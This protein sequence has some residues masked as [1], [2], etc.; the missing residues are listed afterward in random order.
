M[1]DLLI[2]N[3]FIIDGT[4]SSGY[5]GD[6]VVQRDRIIDIGQLDYVEAKQTIDAAG[7]IVCPGFIDAHSHTDATILANPTAES[8]I[9]QGITTEIVGNCG[10]SSA[11]ITEALRRQGSGGLHVF[12]D[13]DKKEYSFG[14]YLELVEMMGTSNNLA[15]LIGHNTVRLAAGVHGAKVREEQFQTMERLISEAIECGAIGFS[16]GL[17]FEPGRS[18]TSEE[19]DRLV[20]ILK[21]YDAI[22]TSH[23]RNR[24]A[25]VLEALDEFLEVIRNNGVRGEV[26]HLN[27]RY[28]TGEP[29]RAFDRCIDRIDRAR[30]QGFDVLADMTPLNYG[31]GFLTA[32]LPPWLME[33]GTKTA[34]KLL[35]DPTVR[36]RLRGDCDRYWRFIHKGEWDRVR[37]QDNPAYPEIN[38]LDFYTIAQKWG[39]DPWEC[40]FDILT[41]CGEKMNEIVLVARLF[42][43]EHLKETIS[44]P[45]YM[46]VVDG[47]STRIDGELAVKTAFPLHFM[48]MTYFL[49]HHVRNE[50]T[51]AL[52][53]AIRKMTSMPANHFRLSGR[54][55]IKKNYYAD[56]V[57]FDF[58]N[59]DTVST[60][61]EP[62]A[63]VKGIEHVIVNGI[64]VIKNGLHTG[65]RPG[66]NLI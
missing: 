66:R 29:E 59:L 35:R 11:P 53:E 31:I 65:A 41:A 4:G 24:D 5:H 27:I 16:T 10:N 14:E 3:A 38:G 37:V 23:I 49:T 34:A 64:Q 50:H 30:A 6:I 8:T 44:N 48:G 28:N 7:K 13:D 17:E 56:I 52:E 51:I 32:I 2:K 19:I 20:K 47:Y 22:Y 18:S 46:L 36:V 33:K 15:W 54:G 1:V 63:Y 45:L 12:P 62:L 57:V 60:I 61:E 42:T 9:R 39:K 55:L 40:C 26:S 25:K 58:E 43:D 21:K